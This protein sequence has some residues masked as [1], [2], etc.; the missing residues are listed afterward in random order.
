M[1]IEEEIDRDFDHDVVKD[2][3]DS[4]VKSTM[5]TPDGTPVQFKQ[6]ETAAWSKKIIDTCLRKMADLKKPFK[7]I[8]T[9]T[10]M[11]KTGTSLHS[12]VTTFWD[13]NADGAV[14]V[15]ETG[16]TFDCLVSVFCMQLS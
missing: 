4:V 11:Q 1:S 5:R 9:C 15:H 10:I 12:G 3:V 2:I 16:P 13:V 14:M 6:E 8:V 7:Y